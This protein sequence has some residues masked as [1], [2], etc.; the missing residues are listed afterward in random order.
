MKSKNNSPE[1]EKTRGSDRLEVR[2]ASALERFVVL[3]FGDWKQSEILKGRP[4][5]DFNR[6]EDYLFR[7]HQ[8]RDNLVTRIE[9]MHHG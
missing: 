3:P 1:L 4:M 8:E 9:R 2:R 5:P 6:Y 7:K